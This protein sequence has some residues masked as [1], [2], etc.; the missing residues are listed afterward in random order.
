MTLRRGE[1]MPWDGLSVGATRPAVIKAFGIPFWFILPI[2]GL[3]LV[4]VVL[5]SNPFWLVLILGLTA[6]GRW[7]VATDHNRPRVLLLAI[8][9]GAMFGD[10]SRWGGVTTDPLGPAH[11]A[12]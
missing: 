6:L 10:R 1:D 8:L 9:S 2:V 7:L 5:T 3:P 4:L 12:D 11:R